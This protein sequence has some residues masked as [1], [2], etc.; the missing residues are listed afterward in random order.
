M[1]LPWRSRP[2]AAGSPLSKPKAAVE[3][4]IVL[5]PEKAC[6]QPGRPL[7]Q[8]NIVPN[9]ERLLLCKLA[10]DHRAFVMSID[11][12]RAYVRACIIGDTTDDAP[13][14]EHLLDAGRPRAD[15]PVNALLLRY[16]TLVDEHDSHELDRPG[17]LDPVVLVRQL[18]ASQSRRS[19]RP[20]R[21]A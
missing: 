4:A 1:D 7:I 16:Q 20:P 3:N 13:R 14:Q 6:D 15:E 18:L 11:R 2:T 10:R 12:C 19:D 8:P 21:N 9:S 5:P 17:P